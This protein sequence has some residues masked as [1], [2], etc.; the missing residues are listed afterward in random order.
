[1]FVEGEPYLISVSTPLGLTM[2]L[3]LASGRGAESV[4]K[5]MF[6]QIA[7]YEAERF[8][9]R[10][11]LSDLEGSTYSIRAELNQRGIRVNPSGPGQ[12]VP[13]VERKIQQVKERD[14][15]A[16]ELGAAEVAGVLLYLTNQ[17]RSVV[18]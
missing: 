11:I 18:N 9:V 3:H 10:T 14:A 1:M 17:L 15:T 2:C 4:K 7:A 5:A 6:E 13:V 8:V 12:H 16:Y